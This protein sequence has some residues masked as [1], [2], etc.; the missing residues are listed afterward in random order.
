[1]YHVSL[2]SSFNQVESA[3]KS[4]VGITKPKMVSNVFDEL[5]CDTTAPQS[6][7]TKGMNMIANREQCLEPA[8]LNDL[9]LGRM[10]PDRFASALQHVESCKHCTQAAEA[11]SGGSALSWI[12][13]AVSST[14]RPGFDHE[15]ECQAVVGNLLLQ[16]TSRPVNYAEVAGLPTETLGPYRLLKWLGSGGMGSV[17]LA[18]HQ[19]LK[20]MAAIKLLPREKLL[21][22]GWLDRFNRE[23]TSIAA[24]EHPHVV[25]AIDAGDE[26]GW[27]FLVMEYLDG[28]DLSKVCRRMGDIPLATACELIRQAALGLSA[29]HSLG[30]THRDIKPSNLFLTRTGVVKLLDLG[31]V[32]SG[33]SPLAAD[34]RLTTVGHLMGTV[35]YMAREQ[36]INASSVDWRADIYSLGATMFRLLT[37]RAPF[38]PATN[39]ALTIQAI[40]TTP[41]P[42]LKSLKPDVTDEIAQLVDRML[43]HD[44]ASRPQS[45]EEIAELLSPY[46]DSLA[47]QSLIRAALNCPDEQDEQ[48]NSQLHFS[49]LPASIEVDHSGRSNSR[50]T[51][52]I[53]V[54]LIPLAFFAGILITVTTDKGTLVIESDE[55]GVTVNVTQGEKVVE[56]LRVEKQPSSLR[57]QSGKYT[58]ELTGVEGD[59]LEINDSHVALT[60][61]EKQVVRIQRRN[62]TDA[63]LA[64]ADSNENQFQGKSFAYWMKLLER[65]KDV[66]MIAQAMQAVSLLAETEQ[67][68]LEAAR[69][70]M[71][72][73][74][75]LGGFIQSGRPSA[76]NGL[77]SNPD[78]SGWFMTELVDIYPK[79]FPQPGL[80]VIIEELEHGNERSAQACMLFLSMF[81]NSYGTVNSSAL[82]L[83]QYYAEMSKTESGRAQLRKLEKLLEAKIERSTQAKESST[84]DLAFGHRRIADHGIVRR[85]EVLRALG[86]DISNYP[87]VVAWAKKLISDAIEKIESKQP[88]PDM[89]GMGGGIVT[90]MGGMGGMGM[91]AGGMGGMG[92]SGSGLGGIYNRSPIDARTAIN[93]QQALSKQSYNPL[94]ILLAFLEPAGL[95]DETELTRAF[96]DIAK[97]KPNEASTAVVT[98]L[99]RAQ[100][101]G[102]GGSMIQLASAERIKIAKEVLLANPPDSIRVVKALAHALEVSDPSCIFNKEDIEE[103]LREM[104][105]RL[106]HEAA[107]LDDAREAEAKDCLAIYILA[108]LG[109]PDSHATEIVEYL[110]KGSRKSRNTGYSDQDMAED[111][112]FSYG[113]PNQVAAHFTLNEIESEWNYKNSGVG[114]RKLFLTNTKQFIEAHA[115]Q[116]KTEHKPNPRGNLLSSLLTALNSQ[117]PEANRI[118]NYDG[119]EQR[120]VLIEFLKSPESRSTIDELDGAYQVAISRFVEGADKLNDDDFYQLHNLLCAKFIVSRYL[121]KDSSKG[122][123]IEKGLKLLLTDEKPK[124]RPRIIAL[125]LLFHCAKQFGYESIPFLALASAYSE[126]ARSEN[127]DE[128]K[129]LIV[130]IRTSRPKEFC[131]YF[132]AQLEGWAKFLESEESKGTIAP[133]ERAMLLF[134]GIDPVCDRWYRE[135][136]QPLVDSPETRPRAIDALKT[137]VKHLPFNS[138]HLLEDFLPKNP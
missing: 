43:S 99:E 49:P 35:P 100:S 28:A 52:W 53:A 38:G 56:T 122:P 8:A 66:A 46:C 40:S 11:A 78:S 22:T 131:E 115:K 65:E 42:P 129:Q 12:E 1:M 19:R 93:I 127:C 20:R 69:K 137:I 27:H 125:G 112:D 110:V 18:E 14:D 88:R 95:A 2:L 77:N 45:A 92:M 108:N 61:G 103:L 58:V 54:G 132:T 51:K 72:I 135:I 36:L 109:I 3:C 126:I 75:R 97:D 57:L 10:P 30:M 105:V 85:I 68:R 117:T 39:L 21:Q 9:L 98:H 84:G 67:A 29:I 128:I 60:R 48:L 4:N 118:L 124:T 130:G 83:S 120:A 55:P 62:T 91:S 34:E 82:G 90:G 74:R 59:G 79:F 86:E 96:T 87:Q 47:P 101:S 121:N 89:G 16:P 50:W 63:E 76:L 25:R 104:T 133:R 80:Q 37:G 13:K 81:A 44:P 106:T 17:Y 15:P 134:G 23:M 64:P 31:L 114:I 26:A 7:Y 32:L 123:A 41:C 33:D 111:F 107:L 119:F 94:P 116:F 73:A 6:S 113:W 71:L 136:I 24:L 102:F 138:K 5:L 70:C